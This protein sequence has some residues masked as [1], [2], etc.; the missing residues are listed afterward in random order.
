[1]KNIIDTTAAILIMGFIFWALIKIETKWRKYTHSKSNNKGIE[2]ET[3]EYFLKNKKRILMGMLIAFIIAGTIYYNWIQNK[4]KEEL[5]CLQRIEYR[6][7]VSSA[8]YY[9]IGSDK[10]KTQTEAMDYCLKILKGI[11]F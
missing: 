9:R 2:R 4:K 7:I 11:N 10:F 3:K 6:P 5:V 8:G 1:M